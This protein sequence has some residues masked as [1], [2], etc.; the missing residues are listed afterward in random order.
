MQNQLHAQGY[1]LIICQS[2]D[3]FEMEKDLTRT[4]YA[5]R[6]D[7]VIASCTLFTTNFGHFDILTQNDI[8]VIFYDRVPMQPY[9][10]CIVKGD[11]FRGAY[12]A[13]SHLLELGAKRVAFINGPLGCNIYEDRY[14][15]FEKAMQRYNTPV[16]NKYVFYHELNEENARK[17]LHA[18]FNESP[19]PDAIF[20]ANDLTALTALQFA[21]EVG[22]AVP[23]AFRIIGYS[24]DPRTSITSPSVTT[25]D[26]FPAYTGKVI[27]RELL[28]LLKNNSP[29]MTDQVPVITP[30]ELIRR[31]ST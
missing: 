22:I 6:V 2:N 24:N 14:A 30:V 23:A 13:V 5:S 1:N 31:M 29:V 26:Q 19:Y 3:Q 27:V 7:A 21:K 8:P 10:A 12:L 4:L 20:A 17:S 15:G 16:I 28:K 11:D 25:I 18:L 9:P